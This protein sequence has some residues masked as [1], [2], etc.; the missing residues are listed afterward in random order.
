MPLSRLA[1]FIDSMMQTLLRASL[2]GR[3]F[4]LSLVGDHT[5]GIAW[6]LSPALGGVQLR[7]RNRDEGARDPE[8]AGRR[9]ERCGGPR[10]K[11]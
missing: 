4:W 6:H 10:Q 8:S 1:A 5:V 3:G 9:P 11:G 2:T 7:V